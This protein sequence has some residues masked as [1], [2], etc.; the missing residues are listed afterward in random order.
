[1]IPCEKTKDP[2]PISIYK[3][4]HSVFHTTTKY[5]DFQNRGGGG[6][7]LEREGE[8]LKLTKLVPKSSHFPN[9]LGKIWKSTARMAIVVII[10]I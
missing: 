2:T 3:A 10:N 7:E 6:G 8:T 4:F 1:M 5:H 9:P